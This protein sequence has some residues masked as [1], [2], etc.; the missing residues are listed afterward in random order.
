MAYD[1]ALIDDLLK[2]ADVVNVVSS[3]INVIKKGRRF[4]ALCPFHDDKNPSLDISREKQIFKCFV[5]GNGGNAIHFVQQYEK[6][7]FPEAV[8]KTAELVGFTDERL[9]RMGATVSVNPE[10]EPFYRC[11][12]DAVEFYRFSMTTDQGDE[13]IAYLEGRQLDAKVRD[14]FQIG[15]SLPDGRGTVQYLMAK[16]HS[17]STMETLG[18]ITM[19]NAA[20]DR[21]A[22]RVVFPILDG[23]GRPVAFSGRIILKGDYAKYINSPESKIFSKSNVLYNFNHARTVA[24]HYGYIYIVEGF[25]DV[26]ALHRA[27]IESAVALM[28]TAFTKDHLKMLRAL[29]VELR[30]C[31]DGDAAGQAAMMKLMPLLEAAKVKHRFVNNAG[32]TRDA[33]EIINEDGIDALKKYVGNLTNRLEFALDYY[34]TTRPLQTTEQRSDLVK[35]MIPLLAEASDIELEV[36]LKKLN[37]ATGFTT[38][39]LGKM[40]GEYKTNKAEFDVA[41]LYQQFRPE[42]AHI[43]RFQRAERQLLYFMLT[44]ARAID[45]YKQKIEYFFDD[46]YRAIANFI[47]E[48]SATEDVPS[49][50]SL[51]SDI[52]ELQTDKKDDIL[53]EVTSLALEKNYPRCDEA[54]LEEIHEVITLERDAFHER[55]L[56]EKSLIGKDER[57]K[58]RIIDEYNKKKRGTLRGPVAKK[59]A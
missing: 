30:I 4:L 43:R 10:L 55:Q 19:A 9:T 42:A 29:N 15:Y 24:R 53:K 46:I 28:G 22:G 56:L 26:I 48:R 21:L 54:L 8:R 14:R 38:Q 37:Q 20:V 52:D 6:I 25:M 47:I 51:L 11:M 27:G 31:L 2:Q 35:L 39:T 57:E 23:A 16:G 12:K 34:A 49:I 45:F 40:I 33:D 13:G 3:Y 50:N 7:T 32:D 59:G 58:A 5:C 36:Y 18:L 41:K 1:R 17:R 44:D